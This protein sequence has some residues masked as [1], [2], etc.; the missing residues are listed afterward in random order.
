M[1]LHPKPWRN[2]K[3]AIVENASSNVVWSGKR[4][5]FVPVMRAIARHGKMAD[6]HEST[7]TVFFP[8]FTAATPQQMLAS[9]GRLISPDT[10]KWWAEAIESQLGE[11]YRI[12]A[13][14]L[15]QL[16]KSG[17]Q[18]SVM[19]MEFGQLSDDQYSPFLE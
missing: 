9:N 5:S 18:C 10:L 16:G 12:L 11:E 13:L 17:A 19:A 1:S 4:V 8:W 3:M 15:K 14:H 2:W 7:Y 6:D